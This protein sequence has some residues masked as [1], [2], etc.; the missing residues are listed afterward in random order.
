MELTFPEHSTQQ[1]QSTHSP[2]RITFQGREQALISTFIKP[3]ILSILFSDQSRMKLLIN[4]RKNSRKFTNTQRLKKDSPQSNGSKVDKLVE[5]RIKYTQ[6]GVLEQKCLYHQRAT[7]A[8]HTYYIGQVWL[9]IH[10][11]QERKKH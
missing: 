11:T 10:I 3:Q 1:P 7:L 8:R 6:K 4:H 2:R 9:N 5:C